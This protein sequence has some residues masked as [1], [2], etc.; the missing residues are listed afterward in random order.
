MTEQYG[1]PEQQQPAYEALDALLEQIPSQNGEGC[2]QIYRDYKELFENAPG[3]S[4]N[5]QAWPGGYYDHVT[6][7]MN[8]AAVL[9]DSL[10]SAR[11]LPFDKSDAL[12]VMFLHDLEKPFKYKIDEQGNFTDN[13][14][15]PDKAARAAKR[16]EVM[17]QYGIE[18]N[19]QQANAMRFVEGIRDEDYTPGA[20]LMGELAALCHSADI[21]SARLW[22]NYPLPEGQD[23]WQGAGRVSPQA[24]NFVLKTELAE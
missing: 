3:S 8:V 2:R 5:H 11:T 13:P 21:L 1:T 7:T 17:R 24:A 23:E 6:D 15:I 19:A 18:L 20:R 22:Y 10:N 14:D 4:H 9:Y 16:N 12:L